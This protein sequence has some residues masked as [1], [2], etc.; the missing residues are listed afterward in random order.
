MVQHVNQTAATLHGLLQW[1]NM[2]KVKQRE[3]N[4]RGTKYCFWVVEM[5]VACEWLVVSWVFLGCDW[6]TV[7]S[8]DRKVFHV[9]DYYLKLFI[10]Y[11]HQDA[12]VII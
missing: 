2:S 8:I 3:M 7:L 1:Y 4:E 11:D 12:D 6:L 9:S 10:W 5:F